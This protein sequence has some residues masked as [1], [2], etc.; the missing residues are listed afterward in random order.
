MLLLRLAVLR[1]CCLLRS[2]WLLNVPQRCLSVLVGIA[3]PS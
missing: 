1:A 3:A 2:A